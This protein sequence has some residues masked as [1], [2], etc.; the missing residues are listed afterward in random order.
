MRK[1]AFYRSKN[2]KIEDE[3]K[4]DGQKGDHDQ[5]GK[6]TIPVPLEPG[7]P[8]D[9]GHGLAIG[10]QQVGTIF[11]GEGLGRPGRIP[12]TTADPF[13][14]M[15]AGSETFWIKG[16]L[17]AADL[18]AIRVTDVDGVFFRILGQE[19]D[20]CVEVVPSLTLKKPFSNP[21]IQTVFT[22]IPRP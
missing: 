17:G 15:G 3:V 19:R 16:E 9:R 1:W 5:S 21:T 20:P 6:G 4:Q 13:L 2:E 22:A 12:A 8:F 14:A 10:F 11:S 18:T 7:P